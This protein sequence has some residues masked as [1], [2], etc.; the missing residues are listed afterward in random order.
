MLEL[1]DEPDEDAAATVAEELVVAPTLAVE[2]TIDGLT[3]RVT[4]S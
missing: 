3:G 4:I 2:D 1:A